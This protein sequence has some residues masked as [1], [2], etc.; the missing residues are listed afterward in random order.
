MSDQPKTRLSL[1]LRLRHPDDAAAWQE[2][3][4]IYQPLVFRLARTKGLQEADALDTTQEV[5]TRIA[6]AINSWDANPNRGSFR[7]WISRITRN[8]VVDFMRSNNRRPLTGDDELIDDLTHVADGNSAETELFDLEHE[9]QV[10]AWAAEKVRNSFQAKTWQA[11]WLTAVENQS[12]EQVAIE[13]GISKGAVYIARSRVMAKLKQRV[14]LH[15]DHDTA[16]VSES[17][18]VDQMLDDRKNP[19]NKRNQS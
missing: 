4:E 9:R 17:I 19:L 3:V 5:M 14:L 16:T 7:G 2:F 1:I 18:S 11:F 15:S 8:L 6:K 10:F 13:L 12:A